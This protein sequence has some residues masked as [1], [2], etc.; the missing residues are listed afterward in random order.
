MSLS[1]L[2]F[3]RV[4]AA[5]K[6]AWHFGGKIVNP[7]SRRDAPI[8]SAPPFRTTVAACLA[9]LFLATLSGCGG[10]SSRRGS[11]HWLKGSVDDRFDAVEKQLRG[12]DMA[13][14]ETD[15]RY[16]ELYWAMEDA[17]WLYAEYQ[18]QKIRY[19][20]ENGLVRRPKRAPNARKMIFGILDELEQ[21]IAAKDP[22]KLRENFETLT[23][24][25]NNCHSAEGLP[26]FHVKTP[27]LRRSSIRMTK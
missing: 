11:E 13:M 21:T 18:V 14:V 7:K 23:E 22:K 1:G 25:C 15:Y 19:T 4:R 24:Q 26:F 10:A 12:F 2:S 27:K 6:A 3:P 5:I 20:I 16:Q 8:T 17:N 9:A